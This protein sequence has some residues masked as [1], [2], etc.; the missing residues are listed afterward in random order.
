MRQGDS[1][2]KPFVVKTGQQ[3]A[4]AVMVAQRDCLGAERVVVFGAFVVTAN[5][6][7]QVA[8]FGFGTGCL[9]VGNLL[10]RYQQCG[11]SVHQRGFAGTDIAGQQAVIT[12]RI[13]NPDFFVER[14]PV[15]DLQ[16]GQAKTRSGRVIGKIKRVCLHGPGTPSVFH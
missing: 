11:Q 3:H 9:V 13:G 8:L 14:T 2:A 5:I 4:V 16:G 12:A 6:R 7:G 1:L 15:E 10:A